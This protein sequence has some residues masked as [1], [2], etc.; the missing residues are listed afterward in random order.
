MMELY[1][2]RGHKDGLSYPQKTLYHLGDKH[3]EDQATVDQNYIS[4]KYMARNM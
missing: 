3:H 4:P 1:G 2:K